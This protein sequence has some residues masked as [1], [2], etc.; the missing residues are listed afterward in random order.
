M[1]DSKAAP[2]HGIHHLGLTVPDLEKAYDFFTRVLRFEKVGEKADYPAVFL[3]DGSV[4]LTLWQAED[5]GTAV[6]F[7]RKRV[8]GLHHFALRVADAAALEDL[9]KRLCEEP[10]V[11]F[12]FGP[13][14]LGAGPTRHAI[15]SI[16]GG[17]RLELIAPASA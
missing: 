8:I 3:S 12:E 5:P 1:T 11:E 7:D 9:H 15:C 13:E 2:T 4:M 10:E 16:P 6:P 14:A 17:I